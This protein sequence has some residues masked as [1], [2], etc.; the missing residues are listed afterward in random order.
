MLGSHL[1]VSKKNGIRKITIRGR[2]KESSVIT[3]ERDG[4]GGTPSIIVTI[5]CKSIL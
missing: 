5:H 2:G 1:I 4:G 3:A